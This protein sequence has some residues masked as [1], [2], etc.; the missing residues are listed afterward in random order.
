MIDIRQTPQYA[1]YLR[2]LEWIVDRKG[3]INYFIKPLPIIG[4]VIKLQR[5]EDITTK[6]LIRLSK[7]YR[8]FQIIVEPKNKMQ[9]DYIISCGYKKSKNPYLPTKTLLL[10]LTKKRQTLLKNMKKDARRAI[11][12]T[13]DQKLTDSNVT[14]FRKSWKKAVGLKRYVP[15]EKNLKA[16]KKAF[17]KNALFLMTKKGSAGAIFL[18][19]DKIAYYWQAFTNKEGR[20]ELSQYRIVWEGILWAK[21]KGVKVFDFE[22]IYDKRFPNESWKGFSHFKK[23]FGGEVVKYSGAFTRLRLPI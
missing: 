7:K 13:K 8:A 22:G 2:K 3:E 23:S 16:L 1:K 20:D 17:G 5:P 4:S 11:K 18:K 15:P 14:R 21:K 10:E 6:A 9:R 19:G 12:K